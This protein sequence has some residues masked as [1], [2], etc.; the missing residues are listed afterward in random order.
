MAEEAVNTREFGADECCRVLDMFLADMREL[1]NTQRAEI[2]A[3]PDEML[4]GRRERVGAMQVAASR[5]I[6]KKRTST[7]KWLKR[8]QELVALQQQTQELETHLAFL[9]LQR[10]RK[11]SSPT[12]PSV[13]SE[14]KKWTS[15]ATREKMRL[16]A[17]R[18]ENAVFEASSSRV[19]AVFVQF[20]SGSSCYQLE[21]AAHKCR[22]LY[23]YFSSGTGYAQ[24]ELLKRLELI[25]VSWISRPSWRDIEKGLQLLTMKTSKYAVEK[26]QDRL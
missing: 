21:S 17:A 9:M 16:Q 23:D 7:P 26:A 19:R 4:K 13:L 15:A 3:Q 24:L 20:T 25:C 12:P 6:N 5:A 2:G 8:K 14:L 22:D 10:E 1:N 11:C 18:D